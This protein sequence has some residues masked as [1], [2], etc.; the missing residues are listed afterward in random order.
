MRRSDASARHAFIY[1]S[2]KI[3]FL[4]VVLFA[5]FSP[6]TWDIVL[7]RLCNSSLLTLVLVCDLLKVP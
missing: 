2:G 6:G 3:I 7:V 1:C 5:G 4:I